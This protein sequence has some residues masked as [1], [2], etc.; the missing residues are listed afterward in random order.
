MRDQWGSRGV[1]RAGTNHA[2]SVGQQVAPAGAAAMKHTCT[3]MAAAVRN[4]LHRSSKYSR[5][6]RRGTKP[7][8]LPVPVHSQR[9]NHGKQA[10]VSLPA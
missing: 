2:R 7:G 3:R 4:C 5:T 6:Q 10:E 8:C 1:N 9:T